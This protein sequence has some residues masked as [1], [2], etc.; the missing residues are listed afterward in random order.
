MLFNYELTLMTAGILAEAD[1][2]KV[3][4]K[5]KKLLPKEVNIVK[6]DDW[7]LKDLAYNIDKNAKA[8]M[9]QVHFVSESAPIKDLNK[10]LNIEEGLMR[11]LLLK[12][13]P[14]KEGKV[15]PVAKKKK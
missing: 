8:R 3:I 1:S 9:V 10:A 7:C 11:Y 14:V 4:E 6:E 2:K 5:V 15:E 12:H 13:N